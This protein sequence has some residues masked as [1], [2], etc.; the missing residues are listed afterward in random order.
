MKT[1][2]SGKI[3]RRNPS[4]LGKTM[5]RNDDGQTKPD[6]NIFENTAKNDLDLTQ[7]NYE[8]TKN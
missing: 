1:G 2:K 8:N 3:H 5:E 6:F 4:D 7:S